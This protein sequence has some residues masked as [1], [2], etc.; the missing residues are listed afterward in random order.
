MRIVH[1]A[2]IN[3]TEFRQ[4][5]FRDVAEFRFQ[6]LSNDLSARD[7]VCLQ[8]EFGKLGRV[9]LIVYQQCSF[10]HKDIWQIDEGISKY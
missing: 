5:G 2:Q 3:F 6:S 4:I 8:T 9:V 10:Y 1:V 7:G